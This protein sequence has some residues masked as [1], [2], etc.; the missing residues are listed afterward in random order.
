MQQKVW[1]LMAAAAMLAAPVGV[2][3][4]DI[5]TF[6][7]FGDF[8][9]FLQ[10]L[11]GSTENVLTPG[12]LTGTT[13]SGFTN[14]TNTQVNVRS[15]NMTTL[16]VATAN[17]QARFTGVGGSS[18]GT[19][20]FEISLPGRTFTAIAFNLD[21]PQGVTGNVSIV[22]REPNGDMTPLTYNLGA[23]ANFFGAVAIMGQSIQNVTVS[24][25]TAIA[26]L[27][28]VRVGGITTPGGGTSVVPEPSTYMLLGTGLLA[29]GGIATRRRR[30]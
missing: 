19:G 20:G 4:A 14:Q 11:G 6:T 24:G 30:S 15:L 2:A 9:S 22:T 10:S 28:Q 25:T 29:I 3:R 12:T 23:G 17:G 5:I 8:S 27:E 7:T 1:G 26:S 18:I 13:V 21:A 16:S